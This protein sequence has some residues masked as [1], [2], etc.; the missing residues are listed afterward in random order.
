M[1]L[2][3]PFSSSLIASVFVAALVGCGGT[4]SVLDGPRTTTLDAGPADAPGEE[5]PVVVDAGARDAAHDGAATDAAVGPC[6]VLDPSTAAI[7]T[8]SLVPKEA[9]DPA[10][11]AIQD[12]A[13]ALSAI[14]V[15]TGPGGLSGPIEADVR[16]RLESN[17]SP[18]P[19]LTRARGVAAAG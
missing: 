14:D 1:K 8:M 12:G 6:N 4:D 17:F 15:Y 7:A 19:V 2:S 3:F 5:S 9:P 16:W 10:G 13:Y 18:D 11:G